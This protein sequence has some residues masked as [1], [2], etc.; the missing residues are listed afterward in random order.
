[1]LPSFPISCQYFFWGI[2][3]D[4]LPNK[5]LA[6]ESIFQRQLLGKP[7]PRHPPWTLCLHLI[8]TKPFT[9][10]LLTFLKNNQIMKKL[11]FT[12]STKN[13]KYKIGVFFFLWSGKFGVTNSWIAMTVP[14]WH[15][16]RGSFCLSSQSVITCP[17]H[18]VFQIWGRKY[19]DG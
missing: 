1:M 14:Q 18:L 4:S 3:L 2:S 12:T 13:P 11:H 10:S 19:R 5:F 15:Q 17:G 9:P 8:T 6:L 16:G 7:K